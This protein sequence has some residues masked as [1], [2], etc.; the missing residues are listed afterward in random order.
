MASGA[1]P[2]VSYLLVSYDS[3]EELRQT[4]P[5]LDPELADGD[6]VIVAD[7]GPDGRAAEVVRE[8][9][10]RA[11][12]L[13]MDGNRGFAAAVNAAA[14]RASGE[15]LVVLN[16]DARPLP[17]FGAAIRRPLADGRGW[18]AWQGLVACEGGTR[19]NSAGNP[20]HFTGIAWAGGHGE[21]LPP[22][23]AA[24]EVA[25]ASGACLAVTR[26]RWLDLGGFPEDFFL[27]HEDI[28]ISMRI[29]LE[30]GRVGLEPSAVVDHDYEFGGSEQKWRWLERNRWA[31]LLRVYPAPLLALV[32]PA[33]LATEP[34]L[35]VVAARGGWLRQ[36]L[37]A[38]VD[39]VRWLP[40][41]LDERR[42]VQR[43]RAVSAGEFAGWLTADLDSPFIGGFARRGPVRA[44]LRLY[45]RLVRAFLR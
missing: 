12:L 15:L 29:H 33:L 40:R 26:L 36:K 17:G 13:P 43:R 6:E 1:G 9:A 35:L 25:A 7:N 8:L 28:D 18:D 16:P 20:V 45:W 10:P 30:G 42:A 5:A 32:L 41:L 4:L 19:V 39:L 44:A 22:P 34:V 37:L 2:A 21:P 14:R 27:Y 3:A 24:G 23:P 31:F 11:L 38:G